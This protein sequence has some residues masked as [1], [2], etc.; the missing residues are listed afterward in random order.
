MSLEKVPA[1]T[2]RA[3]IEE[4]KQFKRS[5]KLI[6]L[7]AKQQK[8]DFNTA[9]QE[10]AEP[11]MENYDSL[12]QAF[13]AIS[14]EGAA[15]AKDIK[16]S[17]VKPL[18]QMVQKNVTPPEKTVKGIIELHS[19]DPK[20]VDVLK[21]TLTEAGKAAKGAKV[22]MVYVGSSKF[23]VKVTAHDY[24][25]A[26]RG[27]KGIGEKAVALIQQAKGQGKFESLD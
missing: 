4:L 15:A 2:Q 16:A 20:G 8:K 17:W 7:M 5:Q 23:Q 21:K 3:K 6:E 9:W 14:L 26:E 1:R 11:L 25:E 18:V 12:Y 13:E 10:V 24:K 27:L 19:L 22:E